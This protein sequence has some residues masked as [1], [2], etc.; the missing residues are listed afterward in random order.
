[1]LTAIDWDF[2]VWNP[3][4]EAVRLYCPAIRL[5]NSKCPALSAVIWRLWFCESTSVTSAPGTTAPEA[6]KTVPAIPP[7]C[8]NCA[9]A[10]GDATRR[11]RAKP[12][13]RTLIHAA[14][15]DGLVARLD[16]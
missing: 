13:T 8:A 15:E 9:S 4:C 2:S 14:N 6:S 5:L 12:R 11:R 1:M 7:R 3:S 16:L 10:C